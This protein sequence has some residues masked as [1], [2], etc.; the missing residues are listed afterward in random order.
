MITEEEV[1]QWWIAPPRRWH[2]G[3]PIAAMVDQL[4]SEPLL[5]QELDF[6]PFLWSLGGYFH[7]D[8]VTHTIEFIKFTSSLSKAKDLWTHH[9]F[10][11]LSHLRFL[12]SSALRYISQCLR[13]LTVGSSLTDQH[14]TLFKDEDVLLSTVRSPEAGCVG[15][16]KV[17][18]Q[19]VRVV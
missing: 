15:Y 13:S 7:P 5:G 8:V 18:K 17:R 11:A 19:Y 12:N 10:R 1:R 9:H 16:Q 3:A 4:R 14:I 2:I 6:V